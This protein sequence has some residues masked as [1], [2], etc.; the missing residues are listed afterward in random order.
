MLHSIH[1]CSTH[2]APP[3]PNNKKQVFVFGTEK[4]I[5]TLEKNVIKPTAK[6]HRGKAVI[7]SIDVDDSA[8]SGI[9]NYFIGS[10]K[11]EGIKVGGG[12]GGVGIAGGGAV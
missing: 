12:G 3:P 7:T 2:H 4:D 10:A 11:P 1:P 6:A 8:V 9:L 5:A